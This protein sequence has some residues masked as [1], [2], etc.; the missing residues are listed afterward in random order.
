MRKARQKDKVQGAMEYLMTYGWAILVVAIVLFAIYEL[1]FIN[2]SFLAPKASPGTCEADRPYGPQTSSFISLQGSCNG[3]LPEYVFKSKGVN[4]YLIIK[5]SQL[6]QSPTNIQSGAITLTAWIYIIGSPYHDIIDKE[7]QYGMKIDYNNQ[8]NPCVP[9]DQQ[10]LCVEWDTYNNWIGNGEVIPNAGFNQWLFI[11]VSMNGN[12]KYWYANGALIGTQSI[13]GGLSYVPSNFTIGAISPGYSG[14]GEAEWF[15]GSIA[16]VQVY[17]ASLSA[18]QIEYLYSE[19]IGGAPANL[20]SLVGWWPLNGNGNDYSGN[21]DNGYVYNGFY[22][23]GWVPN[24][25]LP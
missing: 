4:D 7:S 25:P 20:Q 3:D 1:G 13:S 11:A 9:S 21:E 10:G 2:Q 22:T 8:P 24:Y 19:G 16:N 14:Y 17:N 23:G 12:T 15:N 18:N 5:N 6:Y